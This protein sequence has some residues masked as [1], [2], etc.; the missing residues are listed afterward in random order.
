MIIHSNYFYSRFIYNKAAI[1]SSL[2]ETKQILFL[3]VNP[4]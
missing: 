3:D 4:M 1:L 2:L